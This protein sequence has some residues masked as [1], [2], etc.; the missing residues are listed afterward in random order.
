MAE[1]SSAEIDALPDSSFAHIDAGGSKDASGK[2][3]PRSLRHLPY[4]DASGAV[5]HAHLENALARVDHTG[6]SAGAKA[7]ARAKLEAAAKTAGMGSSKKS[8]IQKLLTLAAELVADG[9][10]A[11]DVPVGKGER[12]ALDHF[13]EIVKAVDEQRLVYGVV[14]EPGVEDAHGDTMTAAEI[15]KAAHGFMTRYARLEGDSGTDHLAKVGRDAVTIVESF[16]APVDFQ[17]GAQTIRKGTWVMGAKVW[18]DKLWKAIKNKR[19]T[20]WSFE[21]WGRRAAA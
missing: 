21:G 6:I 2:T 1:W 20:G 7:A 11:I 14:Y 12:V 9:A 13:V 19:F 16:I 5:D 18:D 3:T 15:E 8:I 4:K 10:E 17:L